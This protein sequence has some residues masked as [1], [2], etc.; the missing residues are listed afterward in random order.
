[1]I[2][3]AGLRKAFRR[4]PVL[5]G[6]D[7]HVQRGE[8]MALLGPNGAGKTTTL[9][10]LS[11]LVMP[12]AGTARVAGHDVV[13]DPQA[14]RAAISV[15]GQQ[16]AVDGL[17]TGRENLTLM[18][19]LCGLGRRSALTRAD[20]L[21]ERFAL[22]E[23]GARRAGAYSGGMRRRLDIAM[24][25][26]TRPQVLF[27]DEPTT[28]LDL[29]SRQAV[30]ELVRGLVAEG[31]TVLLTTQ[32]LEEADRLADRIAVLDRGR[33]VAL[34]T[35]GELKQQVGPPLLEVTHLDGTTERFPTDGSVESLQAALATLRGRDVHSLQLRT[36]SL[37][38][39]FLAITGQP[40]SSRGADVDALAVKTDVA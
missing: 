2:E 31:T 15:T 24:G 23:A 18:G 40:A 39:A 33:V 37:D 32:Y 35:P 26:I 19:R 9:R 38:E 6:M 21:L 36:P 22:A 34:G 17:L 5:D 4:T 25:L 16:A 8:L 12:D 14:V 1:M 11:T 3:V 10:I 27:L 7:L 30:W 28:G 13:A 20:D 29:R